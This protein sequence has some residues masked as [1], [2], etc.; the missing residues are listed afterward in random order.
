MMLQSAATTVL[1]IRPLLVLLAQSSD[2]CWNPIK[3]IAGTIIFACKNRIDITF[4]QISM[5]VIPVTLIVAWIKGVQMDLDFDLLET[6]SLVMSF[7]ITAS[8]LQ[9]GNWHLM[10]G[11]LLLFSY[12]LIATC[13]FILKPLQS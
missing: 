7:L 4:T 1:S 5:F 11:F 10:K 12:V 8:M 13:F 6:A 9:D 2:C 3:L